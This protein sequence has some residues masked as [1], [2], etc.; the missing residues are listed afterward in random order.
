MC[1]KKKDSERKRKG[2]GFDLMIKMRA[3]FS[4]NEKNTGELIWD[5]G[6]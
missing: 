4:K 2:R 3:L 6:E 5:F 1:W